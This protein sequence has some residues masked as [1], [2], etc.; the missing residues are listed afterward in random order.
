MIIIKIRRLSTGPVTLPSS[1]IDIAKDST[2][3]MIQYAQVRHH[4][5]YLQAD[6]LTDTAVLSKQRTPQLTYTLRADRG[7]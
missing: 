2:M 1:A 7:I 5:K 6:V 3:S 4:N